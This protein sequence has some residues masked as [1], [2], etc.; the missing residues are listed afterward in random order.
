M[1]SVTCIADYKQ[2]EDTPENRQFVQGLEKFIYSMQGKAYTVACIANNLTPGE[3]AA[4]RQEYER[5]Y[6]LLSPFANMQYNYTANTSSGTTDSSTEGS[7]RTLT[8]GTN[9]GVS[10]SAGQSDGQTKGT[11]EADTDTHTTSENESQAEGKSHTT[12]ISDGTSESTTTTTTAGIYGG[13][14][15]NAGVNLGG[16]SFGTGIN[17]GVSASVSRGKTKGTSHTDSVSDT[18][19]N[20]LT[21]GFGTSDATGHMVGHSQSDTHTDTFTL[22]TQ[23]GE[24]ESVSDSAN[25]AVTRALSESFGRSQAITLNMQNKSLLD[26]LQRL[27]KQLQR[28]DE[29]ESVGMWD[30]AAYFLG[31]SAAEAETAAGMYRALVSGGESGLETAAVNT[32]TE[33]AAISELE[34]YLK[35]FVHPT[36]LCIFPED[37]PQRP[38]LVDATALASTN[39]LAIQLGLP[40]K[41]VKGLPV[42]EHATFA[43]EVVR[44]AAPSKKDI[45]L[46]KV[47]HLGKDTDTEVRL[48]L[49]SLAMHTFVTG[50]TGAGKSNTVYHM[51]S[52][53]LDQQIQFLVVEPAKGEY[54]NVFG[55]RRDVTVYG[56]NPQLSRLLRIN[57]FSFP[58][59]V[60]IYE[61]LDRLVEIFNVCWP[62]YAAMPAVLKDAIERAYRKAGWDL[63]TSSNRYN[64]ALFPNFVDVLQQIDEVMEQ[65]QYSA[66]NKSDYK[67]ALSTR[68]RSLTNGINGMVFTADELSPQQLFD[69]NV[70]V[71][72][73]RVGST[74]T[75]S[76]IMG[77]LVMKLQEYRMASCAGMNKPLAHI[78]VLEEAHN[79]LKRTST[80]QSTEG[81]NL[82]GKAVEMLTN[83][84]AEMRTYGEGFI[85]ADQSPGLLDMAVVRNTNTKII[86]RLPEY[87]DRELVGRACGLKDEQITELSR[88]GQGVASVYQNDWQEAVLCKVD[89]CRQ[90]ERTYSYQPEDDPPKRN[91]KGL[92]LSRL[93]AR[94]LQHLVDGIETADIL[95][96]DIPAAAK[97]ALFDYAQFQPAD[98]IEGAAVVAYE[99]LCAKPAFAALEKTRYTLEQKKQFLLQSF[100]PALD[101]VPERDSW[102][103]LYLTA[104]CDAERTQSPSAKLLLDDLLTKNTKGGIA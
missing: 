32:W 30:F 104:Y 36:F 9:R 49:Q 81:A 72:L 37:G 74:E 89:R 65:S 77:I 39:E 18:V 10:V 79:L 63:R 1:S 80:E 95:R 2:T 4:T 53:L 85:I 25:T 26:T 22:G 3:L 102:P 84:I 103:L 70:I 52:E 87:S 56:T 33:D 41:S 57:P 97:C 16:L 44:H 29:C 21:H 8:K 93:I 54:K 7:T 94:D 50:S 27:D 100:M 55:Q 47:H 67:G 101:I 92:L 58:A 40:R 88:L 69:Q 6:T 91:V 31:E 45:H 66:D 73:S 96:A 51:L 64:A 76:L 59:G 12:G 24:S 90:A 20:T 82:L 99:L 62:M 34:K 83:A 48:D 38:M 42:M 35:N 46:G 5:I 15:K 78:T 28:I 13:R 71:D 14:S 17:Y 98:R 86:L 23:S 75:K 68:I 43:Q 61:H 11:N 60:H 19:S